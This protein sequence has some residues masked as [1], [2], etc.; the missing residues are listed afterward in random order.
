VSDEAHKPKLRTCPHCGKEIPN[1]SKLPRDLGLMLH[2]L[3]YRL[4]VEAEITEAS[5]ETARKHCKMKPERLAELRTGDHARHWPRMLQRR[6]ARLAYFKQHGEL[7]PRWAG[8]L[9]GEPDHYKQLA[10]I[11]RY[12][13]GGLAKMKARL[14]KQPNTIWDKL[15]T[16]YLSAK[17][18]RSA[19]RKS[20]ALD[21]IM[22]RLTAQ[23]G[24]QAGKL[25]LRQFEA[26]K[27]IMM[28]D[29]ALPRRFRKKTPTKMGLS[30]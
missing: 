20:A 7:P 18:I 26:L 22:A 11:Y 24:A 3:L 19:P 8:L 17:R 21:D 1:L 30:A 15:T 23:M 13:K 10:G 25:T 6:A 2:C 12:R 9:P 16:R 5:I 29:D 14:R 4:P 28:S 27:S